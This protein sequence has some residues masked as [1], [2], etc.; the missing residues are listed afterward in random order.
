[1]GISPNVFI[2]YYKKDIAISQLEKHLFSS[3]MLANYIVDYYL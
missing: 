2:E 3:A 1:M